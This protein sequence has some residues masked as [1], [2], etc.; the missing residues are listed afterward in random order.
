MVTRMVDPYNGNYC[1]VGKSSCIQFKCSQHFKVCYPS[2]EAKGVRRKLPPSICS[3]TCVGKLFMY[4]LYT[5]GDGERM[6]SNQHRDMIEWTT[7]P[8]TM[9]FQSFVPSCYNSLY[10]CRLVCLQY[11]QQ[12]DRKCPPKTMH[13]RRKLMHMY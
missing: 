1:R 2:H 12:E 7:P 3:D 9:Y 10:R 6:K 8:K 13:S 5:L 11:Y 4:H